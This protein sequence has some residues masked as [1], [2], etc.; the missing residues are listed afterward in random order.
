ML[1]TLKRPGTVALSLRKVVNARAIS[2]WLRPPPR[3]LCTCEAHGTLES[4]AGIGQSDRPRN[5]WNSA[6]LGA[7]GPSAEGAPPP[8]DARSAASERR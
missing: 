2:V 1:L 6:L 5:F 3:P 7:V 8:T 4:E